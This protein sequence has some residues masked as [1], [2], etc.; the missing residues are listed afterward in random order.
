MG[1]SAYP[2]GADIA[3]YLAEFGITV[4]NT[5]MLDTLAAAGVLRFEREA[6]RRML[7]GADQARTY[8]PPATPLLDLG[9]DLIGITS[10]AYQ[11]Q[12]SSSQAYSSPADYRL[13]PQNAPQLGRPWEMVDF[14]RV[15]WCPQPSS[16]RGAL[17]VTGKW[18]YGTT[19]PEDAWLA[20][21][22]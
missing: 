8:D 10:I 4:T 5:A 13:L 14:V 21:L 1:K 20:M 12:G 22:A 19:I 11:P 2:T 16:Q 9:A 17:T 7:A 3:E 18:G 6:G 15:W